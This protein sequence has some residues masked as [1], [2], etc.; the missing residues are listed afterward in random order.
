MKDS[1]N[2]ERLERLRP[3]YEGYRDQ[4]IRVL[5]DIERS[6]QDLEKF[7]AQAVEEL[8][9]SDEGEIRTLIQTRFDENTRDVDDFENIMLS[10]RN[11][12]A[13]LN[14]ETQPA[15]EQRPATTRRF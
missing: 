10:I 13:Q 1:K 6:T 8:G 2:I 14:A 15:A 11:D 5:A 9:T 3:E 12:L 7:R 4:R